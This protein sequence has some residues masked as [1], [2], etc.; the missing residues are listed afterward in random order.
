MRNLLRRYWSTRLL[1]TSLAANANAMQILTRILF[2]NISMVRIDKAYAASRYATWLLES[3]P[4]MLKQMIRLGREECRDREQEVVSLLCPERRR[5]GRLTL[6]VF[7]IA[8]N[9][10]QRSEAYRAAT[11]DCRY[12]RSARNLEL[13]LDYYER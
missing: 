10:H 1:E 4:E 3:E 11:P 2:G 6:P 12:L 9:A 5:D 7:L 8:L 13:M